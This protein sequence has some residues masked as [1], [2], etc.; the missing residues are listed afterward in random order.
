MKVLGIFCVAQFIALFLGSLVASIPIIC[1][2]V[3]LMLLTISL[4]LGFYGYY[5]LLGKSNEEH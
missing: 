1:L 5:H 4:W 2:G 3:A